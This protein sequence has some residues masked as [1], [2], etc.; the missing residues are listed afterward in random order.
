MNIVP[1]PDRK[2][3]GMGYHRVTIDFR[4]GT[5]EQA[6]KA[7]AEQHSKETGENWEYYHRFHNSKAAKGTALIYIRRVRE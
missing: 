5:F 2:P 6:A 1:P 4:E 3:Q 7:A